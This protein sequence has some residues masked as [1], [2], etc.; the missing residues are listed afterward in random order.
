MTGENMFEIKSNFAKTLI[1]VFIVA[2]VAIAPLK[3][4]Q[5]NPALYAG[6]QWRLVGPFR[7]GRVSAV[8]GVTGQPG[9]YYM[10]SPGGG[11][12][13]TTD[14]GVVWRPIFDQVHVASIGALAVAPSNDRIIYVG[15]GDFGIA[16]TSF[17]AANLGDG[18]WRSDDGERTWHHIGLSDTAHIGTILVDPNNPDVAL[19]AALGNAYAPDPHRGVYLT[20]NGGQTWTR[21]L[22]KDD[23]TGAI[24][25]V[26]LRAPFHWRTTPLALRWCMRLSG[27]IKPL[28]HL[29][30]LIMIKPAG[31]STSPTGRAGVAV[32]A[33]LHLHRLR[34][35]EIRGRDHGNRTHG[36]S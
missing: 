22:Y 12:W 33:A 5:F 11:V 13:K 7:A 18:V 32:F 3:A 16:S 29:R 31:P 9:V 26:T 27:T 30:R 14:A 34:G 24:S 19:V 4:G 10:A 28:F 35:G 2:L 8:A 15:T 20:R 1:I 25:L 23:T 36:S 17:G 6:M 21:T